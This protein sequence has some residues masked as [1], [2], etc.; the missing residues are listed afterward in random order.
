MFR[1][2][3]I[4]MTALTTDTPR[5]SP[6]GL[7]TLAIDI[8]GT[9]LKALILDIAG[10]ALTERARIETPQPATP[11]AVLSTLF[12]LIEPLGD[13]DRVSVG[14]PGVVVEGVVMTAPNLGTKEWRGVDLAK[15]IT[16]KTRKPARVLNDAGVQGYGVIEGKGVEMILTL[17]TGLGC[18]LYSDGKYVP[19]L[20]LAH[21][22]FAKG[23]TYEQYVGKKAL[24]KVGKKKW[25]KRVQEVIAQVMPIFN[26]R[27]LYLGG[28]NAKK[29]KFELPE[30]VVITENVAGLLGGIA[31]W[32]DA[33]N[34]H[35]S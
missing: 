15:A 10:T 31:L 18:A 6:V 34:G 33:K 21:H 19:N 25:N 9:G 20:E 4:E 7:R 12:Q 1:P 26:P 8:G 23:K 27:K 24:E 3:G 2:G 22:P 30:N 32:H 28:G 35:K 29:I 17:G 11:D 13:F 5:T 16:E 14:F